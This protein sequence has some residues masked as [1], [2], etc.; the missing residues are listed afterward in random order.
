MANNVI[1]TMRVTGSEAAVK[2]FRQK[3]IIVHPEEQLT[4]LGKVVLVDGKPLM[5][6]VACRMPER[7]CGLWCRCGICALRPPYIAVPMWSRTSTTAQATVLNRQAVSQTK[8]ADCEIRASVSRRT[9]R[10]RRARY[11]PRASPATAD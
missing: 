10:Q 8:P 4:L 3:H 9:E 11:R 6:P 7:D 1:S 2:C 5:E